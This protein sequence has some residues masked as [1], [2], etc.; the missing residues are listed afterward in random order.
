MRKSPFQVEQW[1]DSRI[2]NEF[3]WICSPDPTT[4]QTPAH[5]T[6][7]PRHR[8]LAVDQPPMESP[9]EALCGPTDE[10]LL[11]ELPLPPGD[12][13]AH[14]ECPTLA[15]SP[16]CRYRWSPSLLFPPTG[17]PALPSAPPPPP[18]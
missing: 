17:A 6:H 10:L 12:T 5:N 18:P 14:I 1:E 3:T 16:P 15:V 2:E 9:L 4:A 7:E 8:T 11:R 13:D